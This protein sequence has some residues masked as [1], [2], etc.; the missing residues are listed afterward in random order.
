[1]ADSCHAAVKKKIL[2]CKIDTNVLLF[3]E[4]GKV[5]MVNTNTKKVILPAIFSNIQFGIECVYFEF[6]YAGY[7]YFPKSSDIVE[8][9][10]KKPLKSFFGYH[11]LSAGKMLM[12]DWYNEN[13]LMIGDMIIMENN[14]YHMNEI[15]KRGKEITKSKFVFP[16]IINKTSPM[17]LFF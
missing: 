8:Y 1:M 17:C 9:E 11:F 13:E 2:K 10:I 3:L 15:Q 6:G 16:L 7:Q 5:G 4:K 14:G 12:L